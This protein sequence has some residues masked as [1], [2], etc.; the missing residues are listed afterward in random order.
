M[1]T[2]KMKLDDALNKVCIYEYIHESVLGKITQLQ[3]LDTVSSTND[4][5]MGALR[6]GGEGYIG[7]VTNRQ[8]EGRGRNGKT[9]ESPADSN[10]YMSIGCHFDVSK[11]DELAALS[12]ACGVAVARLLY[13]TGVNVDLKWPNDIL[14][15]EKKLAG[16]LVETRIS[17]S[18][19]YVV[20]GLGLNIDMPESVS[21]KIDQPWIDLL[22]ALSEKGRN[23]ANGR[24]ALDLTSRNELIAKL[25][26]VLVECLLEYNKT[27]FTSFEKDW[28]KMDLLTGRDVLI[29]ADNEEVEARVL[30]YGDDCSLRV[31]INGEEK[32]YYAADIKLK[33][34][35]YANN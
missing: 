28:K 24:V 1:V 19:V 22:T 18:K 33:I 31:D 25:F 13:R 17:S 30:G 2:E 32:T 21:K 8:T 16:L 5:V 20:V 26:N 23:Q 29:K 35:K 15:N 14:F 3:V 6:Q 10:I 11:L 27:G 4:E 9:W 34:K 7:C 12:L